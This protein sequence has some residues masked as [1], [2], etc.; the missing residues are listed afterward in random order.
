MAGDDRRAKREDTS[1]AAVTTAEKSSR[2]G[3]CVMPFAFARGEQV[4]LR[5]PT[6]PDLGDTFFAIQAQA[7]VAHRD[8]KLTLFP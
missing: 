5:R 4:G 8:L 7:Q 1:M 2:V 3:K 6:D